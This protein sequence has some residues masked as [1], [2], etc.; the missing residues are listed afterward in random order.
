VKKEVSFEEIPN[1]VEIVDVVESKASV[2]AKDTIASG[3][4]DSLGLST[5]IDMKI[6]A[7]RKLV[8]KE[9]P[10]EKVVVSAPTPAPA[11]MGSDRGTRM[12][13]RSGPRNTPCGSDALKMILFIP[14]CNTDQ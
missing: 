4:V 8:E 6:D 13:P 1:N 7:A 12:P 14:Y 9:I 3:S 2:E 10:E 11:C 5:D